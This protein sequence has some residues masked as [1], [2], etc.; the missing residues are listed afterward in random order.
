MKLS[1]EQRA[2]LQ[3]HLGRVAEAS[4]RSRASSDSMLDLGALRNAI[5][6]RTPSDAL[7]A[8]RKV[9]SYGEDLIAL[10]Q[11]IR[12]MVDFYEPLLEQAVREDG[13]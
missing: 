1:T 6:E 11:A 2:M 13:A 9:R 8:V 7:E 3:V 10:G 5:D 4:L 12:R